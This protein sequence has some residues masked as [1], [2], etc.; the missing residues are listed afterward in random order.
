MNNRPRRKLT[1]D[2]IL[3]D[4]DEA[5]SDE[6]LGSFALILILGVILLCSVV[7][8]TSGLD[9]GSFLFMLS[10]VVS[11]LVARRLTLDETDQKKMQ[12]GEYKITE[13]PIIRKAKK[14][15]TDEDYYFVFFE[16]VRLRVSPSVSYP[17]LPSY[18]EARIGDRYYLVK[19]PNKAV[20]LAY[21]KKWW[22]INDE[23]EG[24]VQENAEKK[25]LICRVMECTPCP[26]LT[27]RR[28]HNSEECKS[29]A[30]K[31]LN[32]PG[33][34]RD[35]L[36]EL[37]A[38]QFYGD[39]LLAL[40]YIVRYCPALLWYEVEEELSDSQR[41]LVSFVIAHVK[42]EEKDKKCKEKYAE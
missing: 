10:F 22:Y 21:S 7:K 11:V 40:E 32:K 38:R 25:P 28:K 27:Y 19:T 31:I 33:Q 13:E 24:R 29:N 36:E 30:Q 37:A 23:T 20:V 6:S 3:S 34:E 1:K 35:F 16:T 18:E 4:Y 12:R 17:Y 8:L 9:L 2:V 41:E 15:D 26:K 42:A 39:I 5:C 14:S